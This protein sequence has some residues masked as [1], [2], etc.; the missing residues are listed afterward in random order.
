VNAQQQQYHLSLPASL[1]LPLSATLPTVPVAPVA[2]GLQ[3]QQ[4]IPVTVSSLVNS[5]QT[6]LP[7]SSFLSQVNYPAR[8]DI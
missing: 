8:Q 2:S 3:L 1:S 4:G 5:L 6:P 7:Q